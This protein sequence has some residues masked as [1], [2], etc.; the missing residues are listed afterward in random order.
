MGLK[1]TVRL[2]LSLVFA[3]H[4]DIGFRKAFL[5]TALFRPA[6]SDRRPTHIA[7]LWNVVSTASTARSSGHLGWRGV[8]RRSIRLPCLF[9]GSHE[10]QG[11]V[12]NFNQLCCFVGCRLRSCSHSGYW[13]SS[14]SHNGKFGRHLLRFILYLRRATQML[15]N[16]HSLYARI[17]LGLA[18][19][20]RS[21][22]GMW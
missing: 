5:R 16:V 21:Y 8:Y 19:I 22:A 9:Y 13:L 11:L 3:F 20:D 10:R 1:R 18:G 14:K 4:H 17:L 12:I 7:L 15:Q 6:W 2:D